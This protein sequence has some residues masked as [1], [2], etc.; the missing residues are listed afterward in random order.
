MALHLLIAWSRNHLPIGSKTFHLENSCAKMLLRL[1]LMS[2]AL[3]VIAEGYSENGFLNR[4]LGA[5]LGTLGV[6]LHVPIIGK[7]TSKGGLKFRTFDQVCEEIV[8]FLR[9]RQAP[10]VTTFF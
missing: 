6:A 10:H 2:S 3:Y 9:S 1:L 5:H 4:L 7:A 8:Q